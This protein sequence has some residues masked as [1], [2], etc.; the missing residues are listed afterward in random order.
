MTTE[1]QV[2]FNNAEL[3]LAAYAN[4]DKSLATDDPDNLA[5]L[6]SAGM[7]NTQAEEFAV[8]Y[9]DVVA[10]YSDPDTDFQA[11]V[12]KSADGQLTV[13]IRGT[14][15][16]ADLLEDAVSIAPYGCA[17]NQIVSMYNWWQRATNT[18]DEWVPQYDVQLLSLLETPPAGSVFLNQVPNPLLPDVLFSRYLVPIDQ[19]PGEGVAGQELI[20]ALAVDP[21]VDVTGHSLGGHLAM[22]F[23]SIF[24]A[25]NV[26]TFKVKGDRPRLINH[27]P[28]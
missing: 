15:G 19:A 16:G 2:L 23:A 25:G 21:L 27:P 1:T 3:S 7:S 18:T 9:P 28:S 24:G 4:L 20:A 17:Y 11:T 10:V 5:A 26:V 6:R 8:R 14:L 22:A 12:F 13:A